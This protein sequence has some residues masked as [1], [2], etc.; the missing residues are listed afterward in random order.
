MYNADNNIEILTG[1]YQDFFM[2]RPNIFV[3]L[4][5]NVTK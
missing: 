1:K 5:Q 3:F 4:P 2:Q